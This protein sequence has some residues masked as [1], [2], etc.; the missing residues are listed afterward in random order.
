M[1]TKFAISSLGACLACYGLAASQTDMR[2][3]VLRE[4]ALENGLTPISDLVTDTD[5]ALVKIGEKLFETELLSLNSDTSCR[6]C[7]IDRFGSADGLPN[8][9]GTN[10]FGEGLERFTSGGDIVP[11]N[12]LPLWG[13][14][15]KDFHTFFWDGKVKKTESDI[16]SQFGTKSPSEDPLIVA[17]HLPFVEVRE[18]VM[19]DEEV[20]DAYLTEE[21]RSAFAIFD[22]LVQRIRKDAE[23]GEELSA[24]LNKPIM[25]LTF[26][27]IASAVAEFIRDDF[28]V[29]GTKF[30][31][32]VFDDGKLSA[33]ELAGGL[34]FYGKGQC[35]TCHNG[36]LFSD[37]DFHTIPFEQAGFG[38][39]GFGVDY[40]RYN[41]TRNPD[42]L[43]KFRTPPLINVTQT[44]P[45]SHSGRYPTLAELISAHT[46]PLKTV[47]GGSMSETERR[48]LVARIGLWLQSSEP[49]EPLNS[50]EVDHL[51]S[52]LA[53]LEIVQSD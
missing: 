17:V 29:R 12:T 6:T 27:D 37:L 7:H 19:R 28:A 24:A 20:E 18:L 43:Y 21:Q 53:T 34:I 40:G 1:F 25:S 49:P 15:S 48:E 50:E 51:I 33:D 42:D 32:F 36:P 13:R 5:P 46:D 52:F 10:G 26:L 38:K 14:G 47:H 11:R 31:A 3:S 22:L 8:A 39:N 35:S 30:H 9:I 45:Y 2:E 44:Q 4:A 41:T 16:I 23:L